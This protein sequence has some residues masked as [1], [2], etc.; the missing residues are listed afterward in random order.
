MKKKFVRNKKT[1]V[2]RTATE[3]DAE[4][5][6]SW[7]NDGEIMAHAGFP[8]GLNTTIDK[9]KENIKKN[10]DTRELMLIEVDGLPVGELNY[11]IKDNIADFGIKICNKTFQNVGLG[12]IILNKLFKYLFEEKNVD[13]ITCNTNLNNI[14][15]QL[16][17]EKKMQMKRTQTLYNS[18]I[19]QIGER[20]S[21]TFFEITK[22][23]FNSIN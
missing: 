23:D 12:P 13:K 9:I 2:I 16:V 21:V 10:C 4:V 1:I 17:Y 22:K 11:K 18:W 14:R 8:L 5:L 19:N 20:C 6:L 7:W 15:S 3:K